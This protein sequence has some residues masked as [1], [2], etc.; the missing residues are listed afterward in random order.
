MDKIYINCNNNEITINMEDLNVVGN[1]C[2]TFLIDTSQDDKGIFST[3]LG[4]Y[5]KKTDFTKHLSIKCNIN[6]N[7]YVTLKLDSDISLNDF[8]DMSIN[9]YRIDPDGIAGCF[10]SEK[11]II[12]LDHLTQLN[13]PSHDD[14]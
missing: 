7:T 4:V 12:K 10:A 3:S 11:T 6:N 1:I 14:F 5:H 2:N 9:F 13:Q 8:N